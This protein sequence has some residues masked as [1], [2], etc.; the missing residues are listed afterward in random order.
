ML[1]QPLGKSISIYRQLFLLLFSIAVSNMMFSQISARNV[2]KLSPTLR[3]RMAQSVIPVTG[4]YVIAVSDT[5]LFREYT[6]TRLGVYPEYTYNATGIFIIRTSWKNIVDSIVP[7]SEVL[8]IDEQRI[9]K[10]E[11]AVSNLDISTNKGNLLHNRFPSFDGQGL[12]VSVKENRPDTT[13][14]DYK[15]RYV[16]TA[17]SSATLSSHATIMSTI[18]AGAGNTYY[19]GRGIAKAANISSANFANLLPEPD[20][21]YHQYNI[22]VQN[23]SYGTGIEN[24]YGAD[25]GAYD[26]SAS[27]RPGLLHVFSAGNS[28][29]QASATGNYS[30]ITGFANLTGSFKMAKNII[31][32][33]HTDS[34]GNVLGPSSKGPAY[35]GRIK[36]ELVAFGLDGSSG[37]AAIVS[38][39]AL[40]LQDVYKKTYGSFPSS[41]LIKAALISG[42]LSI[43]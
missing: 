30:G 11:V 5:T 27:I 14:I 4:R 40:S 22:T 42:S 35:D 12:M 25:A 28:G 33:G 39:V 18:I 7:R 31:T 29:T 24:F 23:H 15:G 2:E 9:P 34:L 32:V 20:A 36:P 3:N 41:D 10:E 21:Y 8:F 13:D 16:H 1:P 19:E 6:I 17:L 38:G 37:A 43:F 26:A